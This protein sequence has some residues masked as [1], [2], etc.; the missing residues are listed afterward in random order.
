MTVCIYELPGT[1]L[2]PLDCLRLQPDIPTGAF[3]IRERIE[4]LTG[5]KAGVI[6][7]TRPAPLAD[8]S[9]IS[10]RIS[11]GLFVPA[12][13]V[14]RSFL[15]VEG[16]E[17]VGVWENKVVFLRLAAE[18]AARFDPATPESAAEGLPR[19]PLPAHFIERPWD[20]IRHL[21]MFL[22]DDVEILSRAPRPPHR[23][24]HSAIVDD[25]SGPVFIGEGA[26]IEPFAYIVGP[27]YIGRDAVV[28]AH[29]VIRESVI[30]DGC[31]V[32]GEITCSI[33]F[34]HS[35]KQHAGFLGH[36]IVGSW[37]N[38]GAGATGSNLKNT[39]GLIRCGGE[40]TGLQYLGQIIGDHSKIGIQAVMNTGSIYG[41]AVNLFAGGP[42]PKTIASFQFGGEPAEIES[43]IRTARIAMGRR[44][45][46]LAP[47]LEDLIRA[48]HA[49]MER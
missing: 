23:L 38:I 44:N 32:G 16:P 21:G 6:A 40:E 15:D 24:S 8:T 26:V 27:A 49:T 41:I 13:V 29:A 7:R 1:R 34:P 3:T 43:V 31:R 18:R 45:R 42:L 5:Q 12:S 28:K 33:F 47:E 17:E 30:G 9:L 19:R 36:S 10:S 37:V 39:Y 11:G 20:I 46:E 2:E 4:R 35:N 25:S 22:R 14:L 48:W